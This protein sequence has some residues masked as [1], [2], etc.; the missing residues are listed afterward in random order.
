MTNG[1]FGSTRIAALDRIGMVS[2]QPNKLWVT[3]LL[4]HSEI[5]KTVQGKRKDDMILP[6][7]V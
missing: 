7:Y 4:M 5:L 6:D 1:V 3:G 2:S